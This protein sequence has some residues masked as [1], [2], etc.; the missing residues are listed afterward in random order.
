M[1]GKIDK[2]TTESYLALAEQI[3]EWNRQYFIEDQPTISDFEYD[4]QLKALEELEAQYPELRVDWSPTQRVG[5]GILDSF[6]KSEH[7]NPLKSL[8]NVYS[9]S[10]FLDFI[11]RCNKNL[12]E[13]SEIEFFCETKFDGLS[14]ALYYQQGVLERAVTRGDGTVG[15]DVT[16][17]IRTIPNIPL[18][19]S[20]TV[21]IAVRAEIVMHKDDFQELNQ[22][23]EMAGQKIFANPRNAAAGTVRQLDSK[24][25][26]ERRLWAYCYDV[27]NREQIGLSKQSEASTYLDKLGFQTDPNK[28]LKKTAEEV[29]SFYQHIQRQRPELKY[30]IDGI[31][32]KLN[33]Y[34]QHDYLGYTGKA[35]RFAVA[36]K[37]EPEQQQTVVKNI[38]IQV[39]RTGV[40]TPVAEFE[41]VSLAG[42]TVTF[43]SLH[44]WDEIRSKDVRIGD[45]VVVEKAGDII[46]QVVSVLKDKRETRLDEFP[47][48]ESCPVCEASVEKKE[49]EVAYRCSNEFCPSRRLASL[50]HFVGRNAINMDGVGASVLE[51]LLELG[52]IAD[53]LDLYAL[54]MEDFLELRE[55]KEKLA[56][57]L[58]DAIQKC[59][60]IELNR[61]LFALGI[62]FVGTQSATVLA[63]HYKKLQKIENCELEELCLIDGIGDKMAQSIHD[64]FQSNYWRGLADKLVRH[65]VEV[66]PVKEVEAASALLDGQTICFTGKLM[67]MGRSDAQKLAASH[68][69]K[70]STSVTKS[71]TLLVCGE[72]AGSKRAK[73]EKLEIKTMDEDDFFKWVEA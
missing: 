54:R 66:I 37:Y 32:I 40:L 10:E 63:E 3:M 52:K 68:G 29:I 67:R 72:K 16:A 41:P 27:L 28:G 50:K 12:P 56:T 7:P 59:K 47:V 4:K 49:G 39:G 2:K 51:Q 73:A 48:P 70:I 8:S 19:L 25:A 53:P 24:I 33:A 69:A 21:D 9:E 20:E 36:F 18:K 55:T 58:Y 13:S 1:T 38:S 42:T 31:V 5:G 57:K 22:R 6:S 62:P 61:F 43:A 23:Q 30:D 65:E 45:L 60:Q 64:F 26:A 11:S 15:E 17:N 34:S 35:P 44:N 14:I 46:P 71:L